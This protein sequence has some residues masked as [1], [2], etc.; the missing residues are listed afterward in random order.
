MKMRFHPFS[1]GTLIVDKGSLDNASWGVPYE[2]PNPMF[3]IRHPKGAVVFDTGMN[4]RA[5]ADPAG[6]WG[7]SIASIKVRLTE[8]DCLP[9]QL[10]RVGIAPGEVKYVVMSHLHMDHSG[11]MCSFPGAT[12]VVRRSELPYAW[13]PARNQ[14]YTYCFNDLVGTREFDFLDIADGVDFDLF[15][16]GSI[17]LVHTPGHTPGHQSMIVTLPD[18]DRPLLLCQDACYMRANFERN[19]FS[20]NLMWN[21]ERWYQSVERIRFLASLGHEIWFGHE[22]ESWDGLAKKFA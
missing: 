15:G 12:F 17:V 2:H 14:R 7:K 16:D 6:W 8:A 9:A 21:A 20:L 10:G 3:A 4:H 1:S 13:W 18:Y 19:P 11:E 22:M 5:L